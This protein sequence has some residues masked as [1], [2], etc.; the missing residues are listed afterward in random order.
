MSVLSLPAST[1]PSLPLIGARDLSRPDDNA[2]TPSFGQTLQSAFSQVNDQQNKA[3]DLTVE[4]AKGQ[5]SDIHTVMIAA[6]QATISLQMTAQ[7][8]NK[9]VEAYQEIMRISM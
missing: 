5:T 7:V 4:F 6:E 2:Q 3:A 9:A 8:R 1:L